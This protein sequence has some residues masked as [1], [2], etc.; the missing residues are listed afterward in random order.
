MPAPVDF[1][2]FY[3][4]TRGR[5]LLQTYALTGDLPAARSAVREA[6]VSAWHHWRKVSR[7][8]D[9]ET[10][11]RPHAWG[12]AQRRHQA[13]IWHREKQLDDATIATFEALGKLT[14]NQRKALLLAEL[15]GLSIAALA[16]EI[17]L[18]DA[19]ATTALE[20]AQTTFAEQLDLP[21]EQI[22]ARLTALDERLADTQ[23]AR[24]T[25]IRRSG[26]RRR[27][28]H[29]AVAVAAAVALMLGA[30]ALVHQSDSEIRSLGHS[31]DDT[32]P[33]PRL[34][35]NDLL[36]KT[37]VTADLK[38]RTIAATTTSDNTSGSGRYALCQRD[39]FADPAGLGTLVRT[40]TLEGK[41]TAN[42]LQAAELSASP[43]ASKA[44]YDRLRGWYMSCSEPRVQLLST[45]E[46][47]GVGEEAMVLAM[48][49]WQ[50]PATTHLIAVSRTGSLLTST[51]LTSTG[52]VKVKLG[53]VVSLISDAVT[54]L[55]TNKAGGT[56]VTDPVLRKVVPPPAEKAR[57]MLQEIDLPP[58]T[59]VDLPWVGTKP[60]KATT[61]VAATRCDN[62]SFKGKQFASTRT[63]SFV[64]PG[65]D[66]AT[67]FGITE[68]FGRL[69]SV[70]NARKMV[71]QVRAKMA[72]CEKDDLTTDVTRT[73]QRTTKKTELT[74]WRVDTEVSDKRTVTY[75]MAIMRRDDV[76]AQVGFIPDGSR[77]LPKGGFDALS[78]RALERLDNLAT[79]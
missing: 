21:P 58:V 56:C 71:E 8:P 54:K 51:T 43:E 64:V 17:G 4:A 59:G 68:T 76:V 63:R 35:P 72:K 57:G 33:G 31:S 65:A 9:P 48:R 40:F 42:A 45:H 14:T 44:A 62:T 34:H 3:Q 6:Y 36:D 23:F 73:V 41:P 10:W 13:R 50:A 38:P 32:E 28:T 1:D 69:S 78:V 12:S 5:L 74:I 46:L 39:P 60:T 29:T 67:S 37:A 70:K 15:G 18:T 53:P 25:V 7:M 19:A 24:S 52:P 61:N 75:L 79:S 22:T 20:T 66:L 47:D 49:A 11:V 30:G 55:C 16:R 2:S 77:N 26:A 27:R